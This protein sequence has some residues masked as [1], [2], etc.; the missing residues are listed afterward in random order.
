MSFV[1]REKL[2]ELQKFGCIGAYYCVRIRTFLIMLCQLKVFSIAAAVLFR[3]FFPS[4]IF[5]AVQ[6]APYAL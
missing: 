3:F 4:F 6:A 5:V 1:K 2:Y